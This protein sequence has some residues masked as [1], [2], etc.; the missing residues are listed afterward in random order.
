MGDK[1]FRRVAENVTAQEIQDRVVSTAAVVFQTD[2]ATVLAENSIEQIPSWDSVAHLN[3]ILALEQEFRCN[4]TDVEIEALTS[5]PSIVQV[6]GAKAR[7][8]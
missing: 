1:T 6:L 2:A 5:I 4:F 7:R 3:F 8:T